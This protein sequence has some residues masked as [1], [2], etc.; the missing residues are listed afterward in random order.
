LLI[1]AIGF[2]PQKRAWSSAIMAVGAACVLVR[3]ALLIPEWHQHDSDVASFRA[4]DGAVERGAKVIVASAPDAPGVCRAPRRYAPF[5][6][7]IPAL[8]TIDRAAFVST[9]FAKPDVQ[10]IEPAAVLAG[11]A[12]PDLGIVPW[13]VLDAANGQENAAA[14]P[15]D[16]WRLYRRDWRKNYDYLALRRLNCPGEIPAQPDLVPI[17]DSVTYRLY[18]IVHPA[19]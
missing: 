11:I 2:A 17:A 7:H 16:P 18:R 9:V 1:A 10:P 19:P 3:I 13:F 5:D 6:E 4:I 8:L 15:A 14:A 12:I